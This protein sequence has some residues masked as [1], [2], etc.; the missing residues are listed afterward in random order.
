MGG[1]WYHG[2]ARGPVPKPTKVHLRDGYCCPESL[3]AATRARVAA[4]LSVGLAGYSAAAAAASSI[5]AR[6]FSASSAAMQPIP[7]EVTAWR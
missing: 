3:P 2:I 7:A 6:Y 5:A 4:S 1:Q